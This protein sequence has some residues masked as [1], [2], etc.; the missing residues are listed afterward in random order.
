MLPKMIF[1]FAL[2]A[3]LAAP[4]ALSAQDM[5]GMPGMPAHH[6]HDD[7]APTNLEKLGAVHFPVS[8]AAAV[9]APFERGIALLH[10]FGYVEAEAQ[11]IKIATDDPTCAMAAWG[12]AMSQFHEL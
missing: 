8:C 6:H 3:S 11:F 2:L 12:F 5:P 7:D 10:S 9:Q 4:F 1:R